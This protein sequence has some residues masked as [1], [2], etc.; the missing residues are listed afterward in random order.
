MV[1]PC[2][3]TKMSITH[4]LLCPCCGGDLINDNET[5][6]SRDIY[7]VSAIKFIN[8]EVPYCSRCGKKFE[9][10]I[11]TIKLSIKISEF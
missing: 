4:N 7:G 5:T 8:Q 2:V 3:E 6:E 11:D 9:V 10:S 1:N